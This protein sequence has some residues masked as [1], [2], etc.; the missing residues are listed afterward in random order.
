MSQRPLRS[1]SHKN[2]RG[3]CSRYGITCRFLRLK[4]PGRALLSKTGDQFS[5]QFL[6]TQL[7]DQMLMATS[8]CALPF[9][10][11]TSTSTRARSTDIQGP[12]LGE[13]LLS[14][15]VSDMW[16]QAPCGKPTPKTPVR[17]ARSRIYSVTIP[18]VMFV[19]FHTQLQK[20]GPCSGF[21]NCISRKKY[22]KIIPI[23]CNE[24]MPSQ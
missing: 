19:P 15:S 3:S 12:P 9:K 24:N 8:W 10:K 13:A 14:C 21:L 6:C 17:C 7:Q 22:V 16:L 18:C 5:L 20:T 1:V 4:H 23:T 11:L 2:P